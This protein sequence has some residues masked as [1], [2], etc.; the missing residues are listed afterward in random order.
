MIVSRRGLWAAAPI[1]ISL[2]GQ[3]D[4]AGAGNLERRQPPNNFPTPS[5]PPGSR[6]SSVY[7][8]TDWAYEPGDAPYALDT[9]FAVSYTVKETNPALMA[10]GS[11]GLLL[12]WTSATAGTPGSDN[13][14][15]IAGPKCTVPESQYRC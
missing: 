5:G 12:L 13:T 2:G 11:L 9:L 10:Q 1:L 8:T 15:E 7:F 6:Q 3:S 4:A 14:W